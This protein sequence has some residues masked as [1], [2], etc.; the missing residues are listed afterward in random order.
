MYIHKLGNST[1][2]NGNK[3]SI[4]SKQRRVAKNHKRV[5]GSG[6]QPQIYDN[7][8]MLKKGEL[9]R[10]LKLAQPKLPKKYIS[11]E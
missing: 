7:G 10:N 4:G 8:K 6:L 2:G 9:L 3:F 11:F 1:A 5:I